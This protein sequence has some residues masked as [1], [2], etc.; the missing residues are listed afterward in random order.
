MKKLLLPLFLILFCYQWAFA[1]QELTIYSKPD[2][3]SGVI[4]KV[5]DFS[6]IKIVDSKD[7]NFYKVSYNSLDGYVLKSDWDK[8]KNITTKPDPKPVSSR[9]YMKGPKGGCYYINSS[10]KKVYV[11]RSLCN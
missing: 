2:V 5:S 10:G 4:E 7:T 9:K 6:K 8:V 3:E 1:Q 11:D